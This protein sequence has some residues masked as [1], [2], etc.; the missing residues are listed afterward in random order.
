[1]LENSITSL[2]V[3]L[4]KTIMQKDELTSIRAEIE[5]LRHYLSLQT[6]RYAGNFDV[7]YELD[8]SLLQF[9]TPRLV[10]QPL[11]ENAV[12]HA[13][14]KTRS[15]ITITVRCK[16][17]ENGNISL[18]VE[19]NGQ[20][21]PIEDDKKTNKFKFSGIG[22]SNIKERLELYYGKDYGLQ[23]IS[24]IGV[25]TLCTITLPGQQQQKDIKKDD[26]DV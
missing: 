25:G 21:F 10:L 13:T 22:I 2:S 20:G 17:L 12:L 16:K 7:N 19:D 3:L 1:V 4:R 15:F 11:A 14:G 24:Q 5:N 18:E 8:E 9:K 6:L 23:I 26:A